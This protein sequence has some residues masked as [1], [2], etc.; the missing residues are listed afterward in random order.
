[1]GNPLHVGVKRLHFLATFAAFAGQQD[2][3][4]KETEKKFHFFNFLRFVLNSKVILMIGETTFVSYF[5]LYSGFICEKIQKSHAWQLYNNLHISK[6]FCNFI[7]LFLQLF[8]M[9]FFGFVV[10]SRA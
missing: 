10:M 1:V 7:F 2:F 8:K 4:S 5:C 3:K 6:I 9:I